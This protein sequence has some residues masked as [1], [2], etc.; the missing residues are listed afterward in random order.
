MERKR[1]NRDT[2]VLS[3]CPAAVRRDCLSEKL[4]KKMKFWELIDDEDFLTQYLE[5]DTNKCPAVKYDLSLSFSYIN[6]KHFFTERF[7]MSGK[8]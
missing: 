1:C 6:I 8:K 5:W 4:W 3:T 2:A 7:L